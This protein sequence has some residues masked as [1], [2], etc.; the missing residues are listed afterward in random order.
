MDATDPVALTQAL[1]RCPTVTPTAGSA[2]DLLEEVLAGLGFAC[3]R[4]PFGAGGPAFADNLYA[5]LGN[6][7]PCLLLAGHV[8]V[9]PPGDAARWSVEP[10][11]G[12]VADGQLWGRGAADMKSGVA[13]A[14]AAAAR[15]L[16][17]DTPPGG[18]IAFLITGDEEGPAR[19]GTSRV[20]EWLEERGEHFDAAIVGEPTS[21]EQLGD[22]IK[23]GRRGSLNARLVVRGRQ[24]HT[25][26]PQ[27]ADNA[28]HRLVAAL[29]A[30]VAERID[31]GT[32]VFQPTQLQIASI[33]IDN[34]A[35]NVIPGAASARL[36]IRFNDRQSAASLEA[37]L[38]ERIA[39]HCPDYTLEVD[40]NAQAFRTAPTPFVDL[41]VAAV[42]EVTGR[43]PEAN[44]T[45]G[46]S[47]ARFIARYGPVVELGLVG[48]TMH[49]VDERVRLDDIEGLTLIYEAVL[50]RFLQSTT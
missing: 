23:I 31:D 41:V 10:F 26:Y 5:R 28:A 37:W 14:V 17:G 8:D 46:S 20:L 42:E 29:N 7:G 38:H 49:Q 21:V 48:T 32:E 34:P 18:S 22:T 24:G 33:D 30:L 16:R 12:V 43:Q 2:L 3:T 35:F 9:V 19:N 27:R 45:G 36:N 44:T 6:T 25:A 11:A 1:V 40:C 50:R 15:H 13:A 39:A 47:D 4:L